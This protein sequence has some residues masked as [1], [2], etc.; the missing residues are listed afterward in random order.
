MNI[1]LPLFLNLKIIFISEQLKM[2]IL[3]RFYFNVNVERKISLVMPTLK[4]IKYMYQKLD[5]FLTTCYDIRLEQRD[6]R[7]I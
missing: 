2:Y 6:E 1:E 3:E 7:K 4:R 5:I